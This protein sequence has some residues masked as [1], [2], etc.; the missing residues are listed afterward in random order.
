MNISFIF[1]RAHLNLEILDS[2]TK[3]IPST[4]L[5]GNNTISSTGEAAL[6]I[7]GLSIRSGFSYSWLKIFYLNSLF[8]LLVTLSP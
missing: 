7:R 4:F 5:V 2:L 1:T 8:V 3:K 6:V